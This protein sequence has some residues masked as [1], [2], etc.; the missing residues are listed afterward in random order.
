M[1]SGQTRCGFSQS[2]IV[3]VKL[4]V[5]CRP[6][7]SVAVQVTVVGPS[8]NTEPEAGTHA[9]LTGPLQLSLPLGVVYLTTASQRPASLHCEILSGQVRFGFSQSRTFTTN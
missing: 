2:R 8:G 5:F 1:L 7:A 4:Q 9:T 6:D 3:T